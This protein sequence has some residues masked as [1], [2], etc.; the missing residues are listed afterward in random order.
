MSQTAIKTFFFFQNPGYKGHG[1]ET[2]GKGRQTYNKLTSLH[3]KFYT[4]TPL[5]YILATLQ[6]PITKKKIFFLDF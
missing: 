3:I 2:L 6:Q 1:T 5:H 4:D